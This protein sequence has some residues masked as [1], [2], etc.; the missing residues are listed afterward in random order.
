MEKKTSDAQ[1]KA[2]RNWEAKNRERKRYMSKKSTAKSFIRLDAAPDD[3]DELEKLIAER[4]R[5]LKEEAQS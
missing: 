5:Q 1:I 3:L 2:S 4:R